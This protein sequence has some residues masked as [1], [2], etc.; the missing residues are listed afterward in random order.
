[1]NTFVSLVKCVVRAIMIGILVCFLS[2]TTAPVVRAEK[3][4]PVLKAILDIIFSNKPKVPIDENGCVVGSYT[5][6]NG[7]TPPVPICNGRDGSVIDNPGPQTNDGD[8]TNIEITSGLIPADMND[9]LPSLCQ[10]KANRAVTNALSHPDSIAIYKEAANQSGLPWEVIAA[11]HNVE[12]GGSFNPKGSLVSGRIIGDVEEDIEMICLDQSSIKARYSVPIKA[13]CGFD[14][15]L[16]SALYAAEHFKEKM[17][18]A[19]NI[20]RSGASEFELI[21][22]AFALYNG[23][24]NTQ[25][26]GN[27]PKLETG[28]LYT[29]CGPKFLFEDHLYPFACFD[30]RHAEMYVI[31]CEDGRKCTSPTLYQNI[32]AMT[33]IKALQ[34][35]ISV[36]PKTEPSL[37]SQGGP[38]DEQGNPCTSQNPNA[39]VMVNDIKSNCAGGQVTSSNANCIDNTNLSPRP[40]ALIKSSARSYTYLQCVGFAFAA[41]LQLNGVDPEQRGDA[42][43]QARDSHTY[44]FIPRTSGPPLAGDLIIWQDI[45]NGVPVCGGNHYGHI[46]YISQV[47]NPTNIEVA[48]ANK[49]PGKVDMRPVEIT[50]NVSG[51]LR[52]R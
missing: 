36:Q 5:V 20:T 23:P 4:N 28:G 39:Q 47:F 35:K 14:S 50:N 31:Y 3:A 19:R 48:E 27:T 7:R 46:A 51:W 29:G 12:T 11:L 37:C 13:G 10:T 17:S 33:F 44:K 25:C 38:V 43:A 16:N 18:Y 40:K 34:Q 32:G 26:I 9:P 49:S 24:G 21:S 2:T 52:K 1:M 30:E 8:Y 41:A 45:V 6:D 42:C 15:L 22:A